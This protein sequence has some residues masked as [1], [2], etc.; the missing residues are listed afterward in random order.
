MSYCSPYL[1]GR[2]GK[3]ILF[4]TWYNFQSY[5]NFDFIID[6][7]RYSKSVFGWLALQT[8]EKLALLHVITR[9]WKYCKLNIYYMSR[10]E[11]LQYCSWSCFFANSRGNDEQ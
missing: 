4:S 6:R 1:N 3:N 7:W 5:L 11:N 10:G 2:I 9:I 8:N